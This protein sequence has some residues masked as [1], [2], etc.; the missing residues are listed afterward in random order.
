MQGGLSPKPLEVPM[1]S[2]SVIPYKFHLF[3]IFYK[4]CSPSCYQSLYY[5]VS[6]GKVQVNNQEYIWK[7]H[8]STWHVIVVAWF[9]PMTHPSKITICFPVSPNIY[10]YFPW[11]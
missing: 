3:S 7:L 9:F 11:P 4:G 6:S 2:S 1:E 5:S 8:H 10:L